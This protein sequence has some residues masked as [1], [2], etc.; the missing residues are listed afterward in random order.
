MAVKPP[1]IRW[2][3]VCADY[4]RG[5]IFTERLAEQLKAS[6][7]QQG[8]CKLPHEVKEGTDAGPAR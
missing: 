4:K 8:A 3:I 6:I 2:W 1:K 5:P 7:E